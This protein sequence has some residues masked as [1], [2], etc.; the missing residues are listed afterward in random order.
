MPA[1]GWHA[2]QSL[3][4]SPKLSWLWDGKKKELL[5]NGFDL[6]VSYRVHHL[7]STFDFVFF[8]TKDLTYLS[9]H[10]QVRRRRRLE[11]W[12]SRSQWVFVKGTGVVPGK[13]V[14][15]V[16]TVPYPQI[17]SS[18]KRSATG[19]WRSL[20]AF[21]H[22]IPATFAPICSSASASPCP[23]PC[24]RLAHIPTYVPCTPTPSAR[25]RIHP[26]PSSS[27]RPHQ[28]TRYVPLLMRSTG[29]LLVPPAFHF[30][31]LSMA[32]RL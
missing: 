18:Q 14:E 31:A 27:H 9:V 30:G 19:I 24:S 15:E 1:E 10:L 8:D 26:N 21:L 12:A 11:A 6:T 22:F 17:E 3:S 16:F 7:H 29:N 5:C 4:N 20:V 2:E 13:V 28:E 23:G 32:R 25:V